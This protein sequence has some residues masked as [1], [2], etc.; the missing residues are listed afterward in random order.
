VRY[1]SDQPYV[2]DVAANQK[3]WSYRASR[4]L[5]HHKTLGVLVDGRPFKL[6][7]GSFN[8][9]ANATR[10]Y[11]NLL[12]IDGDGA[13]EA[14]LMRRVELEFEALW[15]DGRVSLSPGEA[16]LHYQAIMDTYRCHPTMDPLEVNGLEQGAGE[17]LQILNADHT[18][19][20]SKDTGAALDPTISNPQ[21]TQMFI[22]FSSRGVHE[23]TSANGYAEANR[24]QRFWL[25]KPS[26]KCK[27]VPVTLTTL[28]LDLISRSR[29]SD[30]LKVAMYGLSSRVPEYG[31][32]LDAARRG[33]RLL[34]LLDRAISVPVSAALLAASIVECLPIQ[35][36]LGSRMMHQKYVVHPESGTVLTG[37]ANM[38]TDASFR[39]SEQRILLRGCPAIAEK[40]AADFDT[41]WS[42]LGQ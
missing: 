42:R 18:D 9:T 12:V 32:L 2:W 22:A 5:L 8:W 35:V 3:R 16:L 11:E 10:S 17:P 34:I 27:R 37:T 28:A 29:P 38:T 40:F 23:D 19:T 33:V 20:R 41:I 1:K 7:S 26:G 36:R 25:R 13:E 4:G 31:A 6:V 39:H 30:T 14:E 15:S 21:G 24:A